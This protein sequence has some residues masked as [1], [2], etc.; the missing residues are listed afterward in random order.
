MVLP[1]SATLGLKDNRKTDVRLYG[2]GTIWEISKDLNR[3]AQELAAVI[4]LRLEIGQL[5]NIYRD[6]Q[7]VES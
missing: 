3:R 5:G 1:S 4:L 6:H 7:S 2:H